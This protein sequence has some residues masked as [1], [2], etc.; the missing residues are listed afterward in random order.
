MSDEG[1][2]H[3]TEGGV[4]R[5]AFEDHAL[6]LTQVGPVEDDVGTFNSNAFVSGR[7]DDRFVAGAPQKAHRGRVLDGALEQARR[8]GLAVDHS[9][10]IQISP[11]QHRRKDKLRHH[12]IR[13]AL[14]SHVEARVLESF[15]RTDG[16]VEPIV[17]RQ[18][19]GSA[20]PSARMT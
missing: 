13:V 3:T 9:E 5:G 1:R 16:R 6:N 12:V 17:V 2:P 19:I 8:D 4:N 15:R 14:V 7:D 11:V 18:D 10:A 20:R